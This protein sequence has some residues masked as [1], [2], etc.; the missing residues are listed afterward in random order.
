M[1]NLSHALLSQKRQRG[2]SMVEMALVL[3]LFLTLVFGVFEFSLA[4]F[5]AGRLVEASRA[6]VRYAIVNNVVDLAGISCSDTV[7]DRTFIINGGPLKTLVESRVGSGDGEINLV[8]ECVDA[9]FPES[10][11]QIYS[12]TLSIV[13]ASYNFIVPGI[14][15]VDATFEYP[16][17]S[18]TKLSEDLET[19]I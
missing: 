8:Y 15:G 10:Y 17:F 14:V 4:I 11:K 12:V 3:T 18:S 1:S 6:G 5:K 2:A 13:G 9:G 16:D 19:V 7:E